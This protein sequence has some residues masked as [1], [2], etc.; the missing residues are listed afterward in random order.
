MRAIELFF[1]AVPP[2][3]F[4]SI[5]FSLVFV[6]FDATIKAIV[7]LLN[8]LYNELESPNTDVHG[9]RQHIVF[10][11]AHMLGGALSGGVAVVQWMRGRGKGA[12]ILPLRRGDGYEEEPQETKSSRLKIN[13]QLSRIFFLKIKISEI[14]ATFKCYKNHYLQNWQSLSALLAVVLLVLYVQILNS[15]LA[16]L[17]EVRISVVTKLPFCDKF[18]YIPS[19]RGPELSEYSCIREINKAVT[20]I[21]MAAQTL[22]ARFEV[23]L[24]LLTAGVVILMLLLPH[25]CYRLGKRRERPFEVLS[26]EIFVNRTQTMMLGLLLI[27]PIFAWFFL[28][29]ETPLIEAGDTIAEIGAAFISPISFDAE[30]SLRVLT[31]YM[32]EEN[33][34]ILK[35]LTLEVNHI[36]SA[37]HIMAAMSAVVLV[38]LFEIIKNSFI[39]PMLAKGM[40]GY[41]SKDYHS[42]KMQYKREN[43]I[44]RNERES[45]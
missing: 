29:A 26:R 19:V 17:R 43:Q 5:A 13:L 15:R 8:T 45:E 4:A 9:A 24:G 40:L 6:L 32:S 1:R 7:R 11:L 25:I 27:A 16:V 39:K 41:M 37:L 30:Q 2:S 18:G 33:V 22:N 14:Y 10:T 44:V 20:Q 23:A 28:H 38:V 42:L 12:V 21:E 34:D 35:K 36:S 3:I 31:S